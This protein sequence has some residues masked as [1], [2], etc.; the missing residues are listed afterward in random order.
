MTPQNGVC[1]TSASVT[2]RLPI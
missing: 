2:L 1:T